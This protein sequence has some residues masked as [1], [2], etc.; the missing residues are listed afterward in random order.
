VLLEHGSSRTSFRE[1]MPGVVLIVAEG[2]GDQSF[3][4]TIL[5]ELAA[6][7]ERSSPITIFAD[8]S[9]LTGISLGSVDRSIRW[10]RRHRAGIAAGHLLVNH[11]AV[12]LLVSMIRTA[13]SGSVRSYTQPALFEAAVRAHVPDFGH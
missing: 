7:I 9:K 5:A 11:V 13:F 10:I 6:A 8:M 3:N 4:D 1:L 12:S 2:P